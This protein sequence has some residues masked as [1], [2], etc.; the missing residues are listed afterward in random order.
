MVCSKVYSV[1]LFEWEQEKL[2]FSNFF[3]VD[4]CA[5]ASLLAVLK[6]I[7]LGCKIFISF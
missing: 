3:K 4:P 2:V 1:P 6:S 5:V 7:N